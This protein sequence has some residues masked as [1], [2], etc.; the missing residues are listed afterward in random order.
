MIELHNVTKKYGSF[1]ALENISLAIESHKV[2]AIIGENGSG[3]S[4]LLNIIARLN[5]PSVGSVIVDGLD[6]RTI[7]SLKFARKVATLKQ[8]NTINLRLHVCD[9]VA[10]GRYPHNQGRLTQ[11][12]HMIIKE[13]MEFMQCFDLKDKFLDQLSG[14]QLQRVYIAMILAQDTEIMLL[15]EPLNNL[16]L[17]HAHELMV[18]I[19]KLVHER[20]KTVVL[21]AHDLN[22]VYRYVD[23]VIALKNGRLV[24]DGPVD[25]VL[26]EMMLKEIY[27][28]QFTIQSTNTHKVAY[29]E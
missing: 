19:E 24:C 29:I 10:F 18:L 13:S 27:D 26:N 21:I 9:L 3:K 11:K 28:M 14:G 6:V 7:P 20:N 2:S 4:T 5:E 16:D 8:S 23:N 12:D 17:K 25:G 1:F 22:I 15:D